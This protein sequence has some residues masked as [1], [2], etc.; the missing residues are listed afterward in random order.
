MIWID[1]VCLALYAGILGMQKTRDS[2][3]IAASFAASVAYS[4]SAYWD[5]HPAS[6][7]HLIISLC[8]I[9]SLFCLCKR[10]TFAA[11]AYVVYHWVIAGDYIFFTEKTIISQTFGIVSPSLNAVIMVAL[12]YAGIRGEC[13][14]V[15]SLAGGWLSNHILRL[16]HH[17]KMAKH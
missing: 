6:I 9:P 14:R 2:I 5:S 4:S 11:F 7:N 12:I 10:V 1:A 17:K 15:N 8:F 16:V 3:V 13:I